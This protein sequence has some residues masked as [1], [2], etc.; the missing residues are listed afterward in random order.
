MP[1]LSVL[2]PSTKTHSSQ[3]VSR[4]VHL[5]TKLTTTSPG[6]SLNPIRNRNHYASDAA[7]TNTDRY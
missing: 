5:K 3:A 7:R 2:R 1:G 4:L 6:Y